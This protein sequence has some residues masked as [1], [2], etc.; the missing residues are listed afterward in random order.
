MGATGVGPYSGEGSRLYRQR[1]APVQERLAPPG[2]HDASAIVFLS[3]YQHVLARGLKSHF[4]CVIIIINSVKTRHLVISAYLCRQ[5]KERDE[6]HISIVV[7]G[8]IVVGFVLRRR[9]QQ[10]DLLRRHGYNGLLPRYAKA[11]HAHHLERRRGQH[12]YGKSLG[13][14]ILL[15]H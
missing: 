1:F 13:K 6:A 11:Y 8:S 5:I 9:Q 14:R 12:V 7:V 3:Y 2:V 15:L 4:S 10:S